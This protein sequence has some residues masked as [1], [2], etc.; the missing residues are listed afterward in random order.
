[1]ASRLQVHAR[2]GYH[3][4][5]A[6]RART[7]RVPQ[8]SESTTLGTS[9]G[10]GSTASSRLTALPRGPRPP[11][12]S[13][14]L[15]QPHHRDLG[16]TFL[17]LRRAQLAGHA[18]HH[19]FRNIAVAAA[20]ALHADLGRNV[21]EHR[22]RL[23]SEIVRQL[24]PAP[25]LVRRKVGGVHVVP[26]TLGQQARAQHRAQGGEHQV[27]VALFGHVVEQQNAHHVAGQRKYVVPLEPRALAGA[28]QANGEHDR[29]LRLWR[30]RPIWA[31][32]GAATAGS[33][34]SVGASASAASPVGPP[35]VGKAGAWA[36][37]CWAIAAST[38]A[39]PAGALRRVACCGGSSPPPVPRRER[40][41]HAAGFVDTSASGFRRCLV[42]VSLMSS[43]G[44]ETWAAKAPVFP[45]VV[46]S[47]GWLF[48][49]LA[50]VAHPSAHVA[51]VTRLPVPGAIR[52]D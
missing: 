35:G 19:V 46:G 26:G 20:I 11:A 6:A 22:V 2:K 38:A 50:A 41:F 7:R 48:A 32:A 8:Y 44:Q 27:L 13:L 42:A 49:P 5:V 40:L 18:L 14:F 31:G 30:L 52:P 45:A 10:S 39:A 17:E 21:K 33:S 4:R 9:F 1:M 51:L 47:F 25:P 16:K 15:L 12:S 29:A 37:V 34:A 3:A 43:S 28:R 36:G 23:V 24:H